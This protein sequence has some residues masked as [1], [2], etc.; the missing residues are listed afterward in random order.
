VI[1]PFFVKAVI[2]GIRNLLK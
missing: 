2:S 1:K